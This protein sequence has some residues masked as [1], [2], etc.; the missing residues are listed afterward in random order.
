MKKSPDE[1]KKS[2]RYELADALRAA[3]KSANASGY[4]R[5]HDAHDGETSHP[6]LI[7]DGQWDLDR[8]EASLALQFEHRPPQSRSSLPKHPRE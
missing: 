5:D 8:L 2:K 3:L 6:S 7:I 1:S 4:V